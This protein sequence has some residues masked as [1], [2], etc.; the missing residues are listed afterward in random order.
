MAEGERMSGLRAH[1]HARKYILTLQREKKKHYQL[2]GIYVSDFF[3][4][5]KSILSTSN[6]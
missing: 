4:Q 5:N 6:Y 3:S 2:T 1:A